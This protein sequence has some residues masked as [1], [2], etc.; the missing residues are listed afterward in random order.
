MSRTPR[1]RRGDADP[2][3]VSDETLIAGMASGDEQAAIMFVRRFQR[4]CYG[5]AYSLIGEASV[6]EDVAQEAL[7]R[8]WRHAPVFD[9]RRGSVV[10]WV[11][12]ITRNLAVDAMRL[13]RS[14]PVDADELVAMLGQDP[15]AEQAF[16]A[17]EL[18]AVVRRA[19]A[20]LG[21][22]QQR[23][24]VLAALYGLT[25]QEVADRE[26]IPLGTAKGRIR[27]ALRNLRLVVT[28][29]EDPR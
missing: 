24:I 28:E 27:A 26:S 9:P 14:V 4:R 15:R 1:F 6:A 11:L 8:A 19:L 22:D 3:E 13:R 18:N 29:A 2:S 20:T 16:A 10:S 7:A 23:A 21:A 17:P 25:A 5:L 12:T